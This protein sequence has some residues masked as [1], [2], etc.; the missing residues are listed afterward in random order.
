M[1][2]ARFSLNIIFGNYGFFIDHF[3]FYSGQQY[4]LE[5]TQRNNKGDAISILKNNQVVDLIPAY[6]TRGAIHMKCFDTFDVVND[7][8]ELRPE[9]SNG[10]DISVNLNN[11]GTITKLLFGPDGSM[12]WIELDTSHPRCIDGESESAKFVK[13]QNGRVIQSQCAIRVGNY[14]GCEYFLFYHRRKD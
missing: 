7:I 4:C 11:N 9:G 2:D 8:L 13:M 3:F 12:D 1:I 10:V 14:P 5:I 6:R